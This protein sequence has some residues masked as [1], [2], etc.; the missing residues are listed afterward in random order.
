M[1]PNENRMDPRQGLQHNWLVI[2]LLL[3]VGIILY[4]QAKD[5]LHD[6]Y[7]EQAEPR[8]ITARGSLAEDE[9]GTISL[10]KT[11]SPSVVFVMSL[12]PKTD[13]FTFRALEVPQGAGSG[14][15]WDDNGYIV[16]N[17]H[18]MMNSQRAKITLADGSVRTG[19]LVGTAADK[20]VAVLKID[21]PKGLLPPIPLGTSENL[22]VGQK[23]YA[24]GNPFGFDQTLTTGIISGLGREI[25]AASKRPI[26]GVIQTDAAINPGNSG[27]PLLDS[28]GRVIGI[29]TA[30][31][32]PSGAYAGIGFAVPIDAVNR[33]VPQIIR[34][35]GAA[36]PGLG[37][38]I[39]PDR[40]TRR[41]G[42][43]GVLILSVMPDSAAQWAG[44]RPTTRG[45]DG[46]TILGDIIVAIDGKPVKG[47]GDLLKV[48]D[49]H[50]V[51]DTLQLTIQ[52][53][54]EGT[55]QVDI[56]LQALP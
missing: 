37:I 47:T 18:V 46:Q 26:E 5:W 55:I 29:N 31:L 38:N 35:G 54:N 20:D 2:I 42:L 28:A 53:L 10:F 39:A 36:R 17:Y 50:D 12:A 14:F 49:A 48:L 6:L 7:N 33:V 56:Q 32:S 43:E 40:F 3:L 16:T 34:T 22:E 52:R 24:I 25:L 30:I 11:V 27:G 44:L 4:S 45:E 15:I 21:A 8:A 1:E 9:Q 13:V 41:L 51:G 19:L 23:V